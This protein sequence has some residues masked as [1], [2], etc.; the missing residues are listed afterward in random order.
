MYDDAAAFFFSVGLH[1]WA[2][3]LIKLPVWL[4]V[5]WSPAGKVSELL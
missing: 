1:Q 3:F 4:R 5:R 2:P